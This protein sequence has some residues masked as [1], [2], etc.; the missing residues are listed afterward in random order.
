[1]SEDKSQRTEGKRQKTESSSVLCHLIDLSEYR[2][3]LRPSSDTRISLSLYDSIK[4]FGIL[5]P[6][7]LQQTQGGYIVISGRKRIEAVIQLELPEIPAIILPADIPLKEKGEYLLAHSRTGAEISVI[8]RSVFFAKVVKELTAPEKISLLPLLDLKSQA[9]HIT[10]MEKYLALEEIAIDG[11]HEG[12]IHPKTG[13]KLTRLKDRH[14]RELVVQIIKKFQFG[15]SKQQK[16]VNNAIEI[17]K[18]TGQSFADIIKRWDCKNGDE[19]SNK[20]NKPQRGAT[21]LRMLEEKCSPRLVAAQ[22]QFLQFKQDLQLPGNV[23]LSHTTSFEDDNITLTIEF[24]GKDKFLK[25][26]RDIEKV[27]RA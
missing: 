7:L 9:Y 12:W 27:L 8:E 13:L 23:S 11:L 10:E 26:W 4:K 21:L 3:S 20:N 15:G 24:T 18:R 2:Y 19:N 1:M 6:P 16:L 17:D 25:S 22:V 5:Q 14:D